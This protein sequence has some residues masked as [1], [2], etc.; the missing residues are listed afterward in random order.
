MDTLTEY[1]SIIRRIVGEH[2]EYEPTED[3]IETLA[4]CDDAAGHY[5]L[6]EMGWRH[7]KRI[8][9][10]IFHARLK[11]GKIWIELDRTS[12]G[13]ARELLNAGVPPEAIELGFQ[14]PEMRPHTELAELIQQRPA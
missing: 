8:H 11:D 12:P 1:R 6:I 5:M 3:N 2:L 9:S 4:L 14:P 10:L 13:I 7:P